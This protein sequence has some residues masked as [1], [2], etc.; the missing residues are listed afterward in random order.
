MRR[1]LG[2]GLVAAVG[3]ATASRWLR[4][5]RKKP[6][7]SVAEQ[8]DRGLRDRAAGWWV[9]LVLDAFGYLESDFGYR[10]VEVQMHFKGN[11]I[12]YRGP[13]FEFITTYDPEATRSIGAE[14][15]AV[16]DL[17]RDRD[18]DAA[19]HPRAIDVNRLLRA[20]NATLLLPE[21]MPPHLGVGNVTAA[22]TTW[23]Q[24]LRELAPDVLAGAWPDGVGIHY[25]W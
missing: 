16:E 12:K 19:T 14:L 15:W 24:G 5:A 13:V 6:P 20:R 7:L 25:L 17:G 11:Y 22:V 21:T 3:L 10:L 1:V 18:D 8:V 2:L 4:A 9:R 23:A